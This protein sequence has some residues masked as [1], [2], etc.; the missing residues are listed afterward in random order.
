MT[1]HIILK[2]KKESFYKQIQAKTEV[3]TEV[4]PARK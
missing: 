3:S 4:K 1:R 2:A